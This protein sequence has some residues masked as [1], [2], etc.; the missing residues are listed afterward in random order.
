MAARYPQA[1]SAYAY[2]F[3]TVN[4][5]AAFLVG[6]VLALDYF[7]VP[8]V[9]CLFTA[10]AFEVVLPT[11]SYR[12]WVLVIACSTTFT[13]L[14]GIKISNA[15]NLTIM[16]AQLGVIAVLIVLCYLFLDVSNPAALGEMLVP[17][18]GAHASFNAIIGGAAIAAYSFLGFDAVTTLSE[19]TRAPTRNIP[20]ATVFA[21][22]ASGAIFIVT[23]YLM[24]RVHPS[25]NFKDVDSRRIRDCRSGERLRGFI[26]DF[27]YR[28]D[29][30]YCVP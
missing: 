27:C 6:W 12:V 24:T 25:T 14:L 11:V 10:K 22:A 4:P 29:C 9:I 16:V 20:I 30:L 18:V 23:S 3:R 15:V 2:V 19:E 13:N 21:A 5:S 7:F 17:F 28:N 8:M 26:L 1:G